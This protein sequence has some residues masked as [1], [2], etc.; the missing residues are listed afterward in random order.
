[1]KLFE[2]QYNNQHYS[3]I[4]I[5]AART[6]KDACTELQSAGKYNSGRYECNSITEIGHNSS[7]A[8]YIVSEKSS[9]LKREVHTKE[10]IKYVPK[11]VVKEVV[12]DK[13]FDINNLSHA[14]L[15]ELNLKLSKLT[16]VLKVD[17]IG[18]WYSYKEYP[19]G[20]L[21]YNIRALGTEHG[22]E[23]IKYDKVDYPLEK[24][25]L[26]IFKDN[27]PIKLGIINGS[28]YSRVEDGARYVNIP[29]MYG[30]NRNIMEMNELKIK[31]NLK[32]PLTHGLKLGVFTRVRKRRKRGG[33]NARYI[34]AYTLL[35]TL[36]NP[37][38]YYSPYHYDDIDTEK[39]LRK[40]HDELCRCI[41]YRVLL[42]A[43]ENDEVSKSRGYLIVRVSSIEEY[44]IPKKDL[45]SH[46]MDEEFNGTAIGQAVKSFMRRGK[47]VNN[48]VGIYDYNNFKN[49]LQWKIGYSIFRYKL[50]RV[51]QHPV[52]KERIGNCRMFP[53][54]IPSIEELYGIE[55]N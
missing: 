13:G 4:A 26:Y 31:V 51:G 52:L 27:T 41:M 43:Y 25:C 2:I 54:K 5:V 34:K 10:T 9:E 37:E 17:K 44:R 29:S 49:Y 46:T 8:Q 33:Q 6:A 36:D 45:E 3:G 40:I 35:K 7:D 11:E 22:I 21:L 18:A 53:T 16:G 20:Y 15:K 39:E 47:V 42:S 48:D 32:A 23:H 28:T 24:G 19:D 30:D 12:V 38:I 55:P 1:M 14:Q 50:G